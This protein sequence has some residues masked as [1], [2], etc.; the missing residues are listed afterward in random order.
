L[1]ALNNGRGLADRFRYVKNYITTLHCAIT[2]R[3]VAREPIGN[4]AG[5]ACQCGTGQ[6]LKRI[7]SARAGGFFNPSFFVKKGYLEK[8]L[9]GLLKT[10]SPE[11]R[12]ILSGRPFC[13][14]LV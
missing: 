14:N 10:P 11:R 6:D 1:F 12:G 7:E 2:G 9:K 5:P 13:G 8:N 4:V 3:S